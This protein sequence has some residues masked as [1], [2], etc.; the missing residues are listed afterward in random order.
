MLSLGWR[1]FAYKHAY[2]SSKESMSVLHFLF[3]VKRNSLQAAVAIHRKWPQP[4]SRC[5]DLSVP[6]GGGR[7][8]VL[9]RHRPERMYTSC[10][11]SISV[12]G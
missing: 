8:G 5:L 6:R 3:P 9:G 11:V 1:L 2:F 10:L 12:F 7:H 4:Y